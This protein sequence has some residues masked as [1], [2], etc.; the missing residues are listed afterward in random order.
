LLFVPA[1]HSQPP[2]HG[3]ISHTRT[4]H[5]RHAYSQNDVHLRHHE[6]VA[7]TLELK[8][9]KLAPARL[10]MACGFAVTQFNSVSLREKDA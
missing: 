9:R 4:S 8:Q 1:A 6:Y 5:A 7:I 10:R 3:N 2:A